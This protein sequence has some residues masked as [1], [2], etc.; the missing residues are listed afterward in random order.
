MSSGS[1]QHIVPVQMI[2]RFTNKD[3]LLFCLKKENLEIPDRVHGNLPRDILYRRHYYKGREI[4]FDEEW[5]KPREDSFAKLYPKIA[6]DEA[7]PI[8]LNSEESKIF[9]EWIVSLQCRSELYLEFIEA[10]NIIKNF[11]QRYG[12]SIPA[13]DM[14]NLQRH[15]IS[16]DY[17][18]LYTSAGWSWRLKVLKEECSMVLSD[19]PVCH[20]SLNDV[21]GPMILVPMSKTRLMVGGTAAALK[22]LEGATVDQVNLFIASWAN[23]LI[24]GDSVEVL[25][26]VAEQ[27]QQS[28]KPARLPFRGVVERM[29]TEP[30][31]RIPGAEDGSVFDY[32]KKLVEKG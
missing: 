4:D 20:S 26:T 3:G 9:I 15:L 12:V 1:K 30:V 10:R 22:K 17:E 16:K 29:R 14:A 23:K 32:L 19:C 7:K 5:I 25:E 6:D 13:T 8:Q 11:K 2:R 18:S 31:P 21:V 24:Y 27:L 28:G